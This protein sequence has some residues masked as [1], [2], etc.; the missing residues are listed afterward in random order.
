MPGKR[1]S[2]EAECRFPLYSMQQYNCCQC[3]GDVT[4]TSSVAWRIPLAEKCA[5]SD[6]RHTSQSWQAISPARQS[7]ASQV[8]TTTHTMMSATTMRAG[9]SAKFSA[10]TF[11]GETPKL[12]AA[13]PLSSMTCV[14]QCKRPEDR[15]RCK[16]SGRLTA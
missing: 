2:R 16:R 7:T 15:E 10:F 13:G 5:L 11:G 14:A 4:R 9:Y 12:A 8:Q 3:V 1:G 6:S